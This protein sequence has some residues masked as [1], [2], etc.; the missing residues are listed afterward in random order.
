MELKARVA[1]RGYLK[2]Q[3]TEDTWTEGKIEEV[4]R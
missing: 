1:G 2:R 4:N 3:T